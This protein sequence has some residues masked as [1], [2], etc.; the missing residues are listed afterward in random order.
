MPDP[1]RLLRTLHRAREA[2]QATPGR[3]GHWIE[4]TGADDVLVAG[5]LHGNLENF[6]E[7]LHRADLDRQPRR[8]LVLQELLH[9]PYSYSAGGDKSHQLLDLVAALKCQYPERVHL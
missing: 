7:L 3:R 4:L 2:F 8:H 1:V 9:G 5:D 6:R